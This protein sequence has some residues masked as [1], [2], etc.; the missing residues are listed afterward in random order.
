MN[1]H[2]KYMPHRDKV[3][4]AQQIWHILTQDGAV[5]YEVARDTL[6]LCEELLGRS[7]VLEPPMPKEVAKMK[8]PECEPL[9]LDKFE[10]LPTNRCD[11]GCTF[12][13]DG[14]LSL[15]IAMFE[16]WGFRRHVEV[17]FSDFAENFAS[18]SDFE[19]IVVDL[20]KNESV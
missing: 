19:R 5:S 17:P 3:K 18:L 7:A 9:P 15:R 10:R 2:I 4:A 20:I 11:V 1:K 12:D 6:K 16:A 14:K 13:E 8:Y